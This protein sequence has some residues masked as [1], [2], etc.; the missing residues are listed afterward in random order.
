ML[1]HSNES[2]AEPLLI[3]AVNPGGRNP[4]HRLQSTHCQTVGQPGDLPLPIPGEGRDPVAQSLP[5]WRRRLAHHL[6]GPNRLCCLA[7]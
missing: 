4:R 6:E 2:L 5:H 7:P 3:Y 1:L